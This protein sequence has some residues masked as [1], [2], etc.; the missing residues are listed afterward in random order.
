MN[1]SIASM[2][3]QTKTITVMINSR[4]TQKSKSLETWNKNKGKNG[5]HPKMKKSLI[6]LCLLT[7]SYHKILS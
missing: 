5:G 4:M 6:L 3:I 7:L 2:S 1:L